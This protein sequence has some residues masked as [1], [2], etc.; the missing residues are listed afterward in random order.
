MSKTKEQ[1]IPAKLK[2]QGIVP[3][4][5]GGL[6][7]NPF[8]G[9]SI[10]LNGTELSMYDLCTGSERLGTFDTVRICLDWFRKHNAKAYMVLLD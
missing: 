10:E 2:K 3:Y 7:S 1:Q 6:V 5:E 9:N 4:S 8:S